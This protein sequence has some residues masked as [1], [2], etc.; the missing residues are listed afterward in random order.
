MPYDMII[1]IF[2][3]LNFMSRIVLSIVL[4]STL[5]LSF[6]IDVVRNISYLQAI[7]V[8]LFFKVINGTK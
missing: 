7:V 6:Y 4:Q 5:V 3:N 1:L 2:V 8:L